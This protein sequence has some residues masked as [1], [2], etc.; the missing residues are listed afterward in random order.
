MYM[1]MYMYIYIYIYMYMYLSFKENVFVVP[2]PPSGQP[3]HKTI[4][5][6]PFGYANVYCTKHAKYVSATA[7]SSCSLNF[8][9]EPGCCNKN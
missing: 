9:M 1:Y 7:L 4:R 8:P 6:I 5:S 3:E 2:S